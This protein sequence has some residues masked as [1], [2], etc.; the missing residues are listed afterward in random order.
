MVSAQASGA[1]HTGPTYLSAAHA[2]TPGTFD[3]DDVGARES[4]RTV[5]WCMLTRL[6]Y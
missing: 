4:A 1:V 5:S 2:R 3:V 6:R